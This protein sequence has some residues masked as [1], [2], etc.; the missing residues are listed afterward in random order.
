MQQKYSESDVAIQTSLIEMNA[1]LTEIAVTYQA[2][3]RQEG[4]D[5]DV[6]APLLDRAIALMGPDR[7]A[8]IEFAEAVTEGDTSSREEEV[9]V[10]E[11]IGIGQYQAV[12]P[13]AYAEHS[14]MFICPHLAFKHL[15]E[16][17]LKLGEKGKEHRLCRFVLNASIPG[18]TEMQFEPYEAQAI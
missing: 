7:I 10:V 11:K 12:F 17:R 4:F 16:G 18:G 9:F 3:E 14:R 13:S 6:L 8:D 5:L 15:N 1:L 2:G